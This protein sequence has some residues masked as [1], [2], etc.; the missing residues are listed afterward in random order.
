M[1]IHLIYTGSH[2]DQKL[3][4]NDETE[5]Q[6]NKE[7]NKVIDMFILAKFTHIKIDRFFAAIIY[8][9]GGD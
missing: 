5:C 8:F 2:P 6:F 3:C 4:K 1:C 7:L 9:G